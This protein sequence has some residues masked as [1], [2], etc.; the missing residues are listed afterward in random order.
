VKTLQHRIREAAQAHGLGQLVV[1]RDYA[2][3]YVLLG[4]AATD[5]LREALVF[6]G[7]TALKKV[8]LGNYRFS[9]DLDFSAVKGP[10]GAALEGAV[11]AAVVVAQQEAQKRSPLSFVVER[12]VE[13][14]PHPGG[15]EVFIVRA[16]FPWQ[17]QPMVPVKVEVT[18]D[19]PVL[20]ECPWL[21]VDHDYGEELGA[22][23]K[24]YC[25]EEICAEKL[26]STRQTQAKLA[27]RGWAR[28]R[29]RDFYDLWHL[30][31]LEAGRVD[32]SRVMRILPSK[33]E[34]RQVTVK[35]IADVFAPTLLDEVRASWTATLG[36]FVKDLPEVEQVLQETK[37]RLGELLLF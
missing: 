34:T 32:W 12:H 18:H 3:S 37:E 25:L 28:P 9:E 35:R 33:C 5:A 17:R 22:L 4:I 16:Q 10:R 14:D 30:V 7:G 15:Q 8:H 24:S 21:P 11:R 19:E 27:A 20:L 2:Q 26:R 13:R 29:A 6:K 23:V 1:E 31:R 36:P